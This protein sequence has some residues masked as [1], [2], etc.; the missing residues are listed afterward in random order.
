MKTRWIG[1]MLL[2]ALGAASQT[3]PTGLMGRWWKMPAM[4]QALNLTPEQ[5]AKMEEVFQQNR[6]R[7]IDTNAAV[8]REEAIM[9]GLMAADPLDP[10]KIRAQIDRVAQARAELEKANANM[11]LGMR[12]LLTKEQWQI[13]EERGPAKVLRGPAAAFPKPAPTRK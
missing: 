13:L 12:L 1:L 11:L 5:Q 8:D 10:V 6:V 9:D 3:G 7:L 2:T 4:A